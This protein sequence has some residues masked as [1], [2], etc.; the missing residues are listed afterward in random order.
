MSSIISD[1]KKLGYVPNGNTPGHPK[2]W[3]KESHYEVGDILVSSEYPE[4]LDFGPLE[5]GQDW[6]FHW[7]DD[8]LGPDPVGFAHARL[9]EDGTRIEDCFDGE[10][11]ESHPV[12]DC[13]ASDCIAWVKREEARLHEW[14]EL[15]R[16]IEMEEGA[17]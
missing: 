1:M 15:Q 4:R 16:P 9:S 3:I 6:F 8:D 11:I 14:I 2:A 10:M 17:A 5:E 13:W 7:C 12:T